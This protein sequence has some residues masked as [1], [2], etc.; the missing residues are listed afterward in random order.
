VDD[1]GGGRGDERASEKGPQ[2][3]FANE[4]LNDEAAVRDS[5]V[6]H[7]RRGRVEEHDDDVR[8]GV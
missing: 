2:G 1:V 8:R 4:C 7:A 6:L 5:G 3:A